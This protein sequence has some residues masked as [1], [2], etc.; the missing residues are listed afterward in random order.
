MKKYLTGIIDHNWFFLA[1]VVFIF[2]LPFSQALVSIFAGILLLTAFIEGDLKNK[3]F[4]IK[5]NT[6]F[7]FL[8]GIFIL[9]I[10]SALLSNKI[11]SSLY[12]L[13]KCLFFLII[14]LA[15]LLGKEMNNNQKQFLFF[16]F[17]ISVFVSTIM[18]LLNWILTGSVQTFSVHNVSFI[19]HIRFSFQIILA[20]WFLILIVQSNFRNINKMQMLLLLATAVYFLLFLLFQQSLTGII[21]FSGSVLLFFIIN[22]FRLSLKKRFIILS[23]FAVFVIV[24]MILIINAV[25]KFYSIEE[26]DKDNIETVTA[27]GNPYSHDFSNPLVENGSYVSLYVC[28]SEM[29][30]E[31]NKVSSVKYD[32]LGTNGYTISTTLVRYLTSKG[33]RK[34]AEGIKSL[35]SQ[36]IVNIQN[37]IANVIFTEHKLSL[38]PRI[39]QTIWEYYVYSKTGDA[40]QKSFAQRIEYAKAALSIVKQNPV[41]GVGTGNWREAFRTTYEINNPQL[42]VEYYASAHNQYLNYLVKFGVA[43]FLLIF[44]L[45]LYPVIKT[46]KYTDH[47][48]LIFLV[49]MFFAN[50]SDSNFESHMGSSFFVVFYCIFISGDTN[51][52]KLSWRK[53][54]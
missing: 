2:V 25:Q 5:S 51:Y 24:P 3:L 45:I 26:I 39:Y 21:A 22:V 20:F 34:D 27:L 4:R 32:S 42:K 28:E 9:Y 52:L 36:D 49:F 33:L 7:L 30:E 10:I 44:F 35:T 31:W 43:G 37:G 12:D 23:G 13:Q 48:F 19:S 50:F 8:P 17:I 47:L 40:N 16:A 29:R 18:A 38:Y 6:V 53:Q 54:P 41:F 11:S 46:K 14:P 1:L 15:F